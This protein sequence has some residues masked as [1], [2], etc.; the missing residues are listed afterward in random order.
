MTSPLHCPGFERF[1][2]LSS[3]LCRC[4]KCGAEAEIF[5]D[6]FDRPHTCRQ[7][8]QPIDFTRCAWHA[9]GGVATGAENL[10]AARERE[11][12]GHGQAK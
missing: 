6:E 11:G 4:P 1:R 10:W 8:R 5:S 12:R 9:T 7:C 3:F 2:N